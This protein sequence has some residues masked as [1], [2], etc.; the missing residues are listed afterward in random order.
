MRLIMADN[1]GFGFKI[2]GKARPKV[3]VNVEEKQEQRQLITGVAGSQFQGEEP[4]QPG[5]HVIPA[6]QNTYKTGVGKFV[7]SF[8]PES[9]ITPVTGNA[10][11]RYERAAAPDQPSITSYGLEVRQR[12][13]PA[14]DRDGQA[15]S[16]PMV[17]AN[18]RLDDAAQFKAD[19]ELLPEE[20]NVEVGICSDHCL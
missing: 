4:A 17:P 20:A 18:S 9:S 14:A 1:G 5:K 2:Q 12:Q 11:D 19:L 10:E 15:A 7:P 3:A 8:V 16:G 13:A 6:L